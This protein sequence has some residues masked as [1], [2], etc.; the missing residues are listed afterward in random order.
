VAGTAKVR[1]SVPAVRAAS[2]AEASERALERVRGLVPASGYRLSQ[3]ELLGQNG[4]GPATA[5]APPALASG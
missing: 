5:P 2:Q 3:P 4:G 1:I